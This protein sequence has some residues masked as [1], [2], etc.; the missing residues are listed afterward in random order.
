MDAALLNADK[1][2]LP[3][4]NTAV[5]LSLLLQPPCYIVTSALLF[6][7]KRN[8]AAG[9][10]QPKGTNP[11]FHFLKPTH[12]MFGFLALTLLYCYICILD[13]QHPAGLTQREGTNPAFYF[14]KP[15][16]SMFGFFTSLA[17]AYS[18]VLMPDKGLKERL[19]SD[20]SDRCVTGMYQAKQDPAA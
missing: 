16:H 4:V 11:V 2:Q 13:L 3:V 15:T 8:I 14:L 20:A 7:S 1:L 5:V 17:D 6:A 9:L 10:T 18:A 12:S 19:A